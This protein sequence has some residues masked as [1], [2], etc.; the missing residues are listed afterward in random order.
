MY[1]IPY[2]PP[3]FPFK[4]YEVIIQF[5]KFKTVNQA[6]GEHSVETWDRSEGRIEDLNF[7]EGIM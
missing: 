1:Y 5:Q 4:W 7:R 3:S 6:A 2:T